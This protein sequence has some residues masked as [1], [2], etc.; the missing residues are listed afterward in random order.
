MS[1]TNETAVPPA[2]VTVKVPH[3]FK[4]KMRLNPG[5]SIKSV[6]ALVT[7]SRITP[8][9]VF[10]VQSPTEAVFVI[11]KVSSSAPEMT[12]FTFIEA[13]EVVNVASFVQFSDIGDGVAGAA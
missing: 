7:S 10:T 3:F 6:V 5:A 11:V 1:L 12:R 13:R 2:G 8:E 4:S 9:F